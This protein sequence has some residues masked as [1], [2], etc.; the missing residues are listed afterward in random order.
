MRE[1]LISCLLYTVT[2]A[3]TL[4]L[5]MYPDQGLNSQPSG[6]WDCALFCPLFFFK[7]FIYFLRGEG[8]EKESDRN[9]TVWLPDKWLLHTGY[10]AHNPGMCRDWELNQQLFG[11]QSGA[12]STEPHQ[13]G[14]NIPT[15]SYT[16][17]TLPTT[18]SLCRSRWSPY[19]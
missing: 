16:H 13:P 14:H 6:S 7:D 12:Q 17:L 8:G 4:N 2:R 11:S 19:H 18:G 5:G 9:M 1:T 15:V 10:L 3:Q